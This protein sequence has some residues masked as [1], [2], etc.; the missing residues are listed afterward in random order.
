MLKK[1]KAL[2]G[3]FPRKVRCAAAFAAAVI[4]AVALV[5]RPARW[6]HESE[7][8]IAPRA[9]VAPGAASE[10][11]GAVGGPELAP[12]VSIL[13]GVASEALGGKTSLLQASSEPWPSYG[14]KIIRR[15]TLEVE[16]DGGRFDEAVS[17]LLGL[18]DFFGG[19]VED[20]RVGASGEKRSA[21]VV[22][23][24]P[25]ESFGRALDEVGS[26]GKV[27]SER[28]SGQ[29]VT[30]QYVDVESRIKALEVQEAR[31]LDLLSKAKTV[32]EILRIEQELSRV[33]TQI[34][35]HEGRLKSLERLSALSAIEV[36]LSERDAA[37]PWPSGFLGDACRAFMRTVRFL[38]R[39]GRWAFVFAAGASPVAAPAVMLW[40]VIRR[41]RGGRKPAAG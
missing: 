10:A 11:L 37:A 12:K 27:V 8:K 6:S 19:Y 40:L 1:M 22:L 17:R 13:P 16:V 24:V 18:A 31:L 34:E 30:E 29:D 2:C 9:S 5:S 3:R 14:R 25:E 41:L 4:I 38:G 20:S 23:R 21:R 36:L 32:D 15:A 7:L 35:T 39:A 26:L 33:R 28:I